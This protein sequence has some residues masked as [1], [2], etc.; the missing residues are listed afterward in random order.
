MRNLPKYFH[1]EQIIRYSSLLPAVTPTTAT[2]IIPAVV[3]IATMA[4]S[5]TIAT[6]IT[7]ATVAATTTTITAITATAVATAATITA[8]TVATTTLRARLSLIHTNRPITE[9]RAV[10][11]LNRSSC[12]PIVRHLYESETL[13]LTCSA[14][15]DDRGI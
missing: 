11:R 4:A 14:V 7:A 2:G 8:A 13:A 5:A 9:H 3:I 15:H 1:K 10:E 6:T 12:L